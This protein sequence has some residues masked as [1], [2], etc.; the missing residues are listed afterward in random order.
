[1]RKTNIVEDR[2]QVIIRKLVLRSN[3]SN[4]HTRALQVMRRLG[5]L[6]ITTLE[7]PRNSI[8][9]ITSS[10]IS[11]SSNI[12]RGS[13]NNNN[14]N[15]RHSTNNTNNS[16]NSTNNINNNGLLNINNNSN[17]SK[18]NSSSKGRCVTL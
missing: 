11:I 12:L 7:E 17:S 4:K 18:T 3:N 5:S 6:N 10:N 8:N 16:H 9:N 15:G 14:S 2:V 1:M 13:T